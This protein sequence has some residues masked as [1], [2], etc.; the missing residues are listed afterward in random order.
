M[1]KEKERPFQ[2]DVVSIRMVKDAPFYSDKPLDHPQ[3][4]VELLAKEICDIDREVMYVINMNTKAV[5]INC[6]LVSIGTLNQSLVTPREILKASILSNAAGILLLHLHPSGDITPSEADML[7]TKRMGMACDIM[8]IDL[9]DHIIVGTDGISYFSFCENKILP[10][11]QEDKK[12][13]Q[14]LG[15]AAEK[16]GAR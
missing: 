13:E 12:Q 7:V 5:P 16:K 11:M 6:S 2:L 15:A 14:A 9:L 10:V 1:N 3:K 8:G 4:V